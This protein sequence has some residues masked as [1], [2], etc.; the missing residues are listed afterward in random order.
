MQN[1]CSS[2]ETNRQL[3]VFSFK[4]FQNEGRPLCTNSI[5]NPALAEK[6]V[7][8]YNTTGFLL[9]TKDFSFF[10]FCYSKT[11]KTVCK[12]G[13]FIWIIFMSTDNCLCATSNILLTQSVCQLYI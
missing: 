2:T 9:T 13:S 12:N 8:L 1:L 6:T 10:K 7:I 5:L 3:V 4:M 11:L